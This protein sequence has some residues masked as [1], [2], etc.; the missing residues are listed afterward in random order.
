VAEQQR[1]AGAAVAV[2]AEDRGARRVVVEVG[3]EPAAQAETVDEEVERTLTLG[4]RLA[5]SWIHRA[6][7]GGRRH[8]RRR[9]AT[10]ACVG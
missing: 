6:C 9:A 8:D 4:D 5:V 2:E 3:Q 1:L 10:S 7:S